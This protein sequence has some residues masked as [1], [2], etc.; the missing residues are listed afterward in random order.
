MP[1]FP[2]S[3]LVLRVGGQG[4]TNSNGLHAR[5]QKL[6]FF[7]PLF[8]FLLFISENIFYWKHSIRDSR[9]KKVSVLI[10][11]PQISA[12]NI[13]FCCRSG[14]ENSLAMNNNI[15]LINMPFMEILNF[16]K[17]ILLPSY[18]GQM[19]GGR[20]GSRSDCRADAIDKY[21]QWTCGSNIGCKWDV[22]VTTVTSNPLIRNNWMKYSVMKEFE[23]RW[24]WY[25]T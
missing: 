5:A 18:L 9:K 10:H 17:I 22:V 24:W 15:G 16:S 14:R 8:P 12:V 20:E 2:F 6:F 21:F 7:S 3:C 4:R 25:F 19:K 23:A 1:S 11:I 13:F